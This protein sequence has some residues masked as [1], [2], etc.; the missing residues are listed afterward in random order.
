MP[1]YA[2]EHAV[3]NK[4]VEAGLSQTELAERANI[5]QPHVSAIERGASSPSVE[6]LHALAA[7]LG[8]E[9]AEIMHRA[10]AR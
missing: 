1:K 3:R 10:G 2:D 6:V 9:V 4:R 8:C 5:T 7:A